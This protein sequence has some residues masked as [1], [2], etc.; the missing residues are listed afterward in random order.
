MLGYWNTRISEAV[1]RSCTVKEVFLKIFQNS[2]VLLWHRSFLWI[3]QHFKEHLCS[4]NTWSGCFWDLLESRFSILILYVINQQVRCE[5]LVS[6]YGGA[7]DFI[8]ICIFLKIITFV[9]KCEYKWEIASS[10]FLSLDQNLIP[11]KQSYI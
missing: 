2:Q 3:L 6:F 9:H 4:Q 10:V 5:C 7:K 8:F 1:V 11:E